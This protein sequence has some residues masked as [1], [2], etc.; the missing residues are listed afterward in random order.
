LVPP[1]IDLIYP[2]NATYGV[3]SIPLNFTVSEATDWI[4]YSLDGATNVTITGDTML[5]DLSLGSHNIIVYANDTDGNMG[6]SDRV[7]FTIAEE[8]PPVIA[9]ASPRNK[10]YTETSIPLEL[11]IS[12]PTSWIGYSLDGAANETMTGTTTTLTEL[13]LGSHNIIVYANGTTG[14]MGSS[15]IMYFTIEE[16]PVGIDWTLIA[17]VAIICIVVGVAAGYFIV[18]YKK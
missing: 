13:S 12:E 5:T 6:A 8:A 4:G 3:T 11:V 16:A 15:G 10:T 17:A 18:K 9:L 2:V 1:T 14:L 7:Y